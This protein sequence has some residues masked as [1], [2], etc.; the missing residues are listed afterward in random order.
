[1]IER[2]I[3]VSRIIP[4]GQSMALKGVYLDNGSSAEVVLGRHPFVEFWQS[5]AAAGHPQPIFHDVDD[6]A[7]LVG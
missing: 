1:M 4:Q 2:P 5:W 7:V 6:S 3:Y